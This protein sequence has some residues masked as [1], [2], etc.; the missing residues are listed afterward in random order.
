MP[1]SSG[2]E[3]ALC[4]PMVM[5]RDFEFSK[6]N[7]PGLSSLFHS[8]EVQNN[9]QAPEVWICFFAPSWLRPIS[10]ALTTVKFSLN[11]VLVLDL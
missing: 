1:V 7:S 6:L 10:T 3:N 9:V 5:D 4:L 11:T 8:C 2:S